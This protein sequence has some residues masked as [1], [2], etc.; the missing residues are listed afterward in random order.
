MASRSVTKSGAFWSYGDTRL[1][2]GKDNARAFLRENP[3]I[4]DTIIQEIMAK[5]MPGVVAAAVVDGA[6]DETALDDEPAPAAKKRK[7]AAAAE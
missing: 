2:Q 7:A 4:R 6:D 1:G 3:T 5:R